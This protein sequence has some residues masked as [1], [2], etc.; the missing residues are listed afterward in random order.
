MPEGPECTRTARQVNRAVQGKQLVNF[1]FVSGRY[2]KNL[3]IGFADFYFAIDEKPLPVKGVYNK[4]KF[5]W[6]EF[7][8][9]LPICYM[10]TT[11]G[12]TGN[13]KLQPS[14]HTRLAFYFDDDSAVY[15][16]DQR[17]FG[18]IKF[19]FDDKDHQKK[20][21]SIGPDMLNNPCS[22]S[23]F[24]H[25]A[26]RKPRWTL[27]KWLMDQSQISGIGNIYKSE[28]LFLAAL[29]PDRLLESCTDDEL[30]KLYYAVC[31]VLSASY[32]SGGSTIRNY[33]DLHNNHGRYTRF[34]SN[35]D[36]MIAA[37]Q[38]RVMVY[39]QKEDIYG[40]PVERIKLN[41]GRTTFWSPKVQF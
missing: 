39:N 29:R 9:L 16:N 19:V 36:E 14:K 17:N 12:M 23:D 32:E 18:T 7:G 28:S 35:P 25:I 26:R 20:L 8:D 15:Y 3:P 2:V 41:D 24:L 27:V 22:L 31:K 37:R 11:L 1:N 40:N 34:P 38:S 13:F 4:G 6:W 10:Y 21:A 33:S 5:I 30:E